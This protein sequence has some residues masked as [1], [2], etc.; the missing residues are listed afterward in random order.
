MK[1]RAMQSSV[2]MSDHPVPMLGTVELPTVEV[3][4]FEVPALGS[5]RAVDMLPFE[6][7]APRCS[8]CACAMVMVVVVM[9]VVVV[10][11]L[12][13]VM[14]NERWRWATG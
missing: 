6:V 5:R 1:Q 14:P 8:L 13:V 12:L 3:V 10:E 9:V 11:L 2:L 4:V 7:H